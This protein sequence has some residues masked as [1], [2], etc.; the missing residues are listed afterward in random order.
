MSITL[1]GSFSLHPVGTGAAM[2]QAGYAA[3][4]LPFVYVPFK[5]VDL[6]ASVIAARTLGIRGIGISMPF[7][8]D[9]MAMLDEI[10]PV[11]REIGAVNTVVNEAGRFVGHNT[12]HEGA[13]RALEEVTTLRDRKVLLLGAGGAARAIAF[14]LRGR[15]AKVTI[16][17]R[18]RQKAD[19]IAHAT[20]AK[21]AGAEGFHD[22]SSYDVIVNATSLGM[23]DVDPRSPLENSAVHRGQVVMDIVYK[24]IETQLCTIAKQAGATTIHGGRMLLHQ[25]ARQFEL[26]TNVNAPLEVMDTALRGAIG[27]PQR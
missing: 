9:I 8:I 13:M 27:A 5:V 17:N 3:L 7:K 10:E 24:P 6:A 12:D 1:C 23:S 2:H 14:G 22:T 19:A 21:S 25:A 16:A 18:D 4:G 26:Y 15:G 11:A 20:G